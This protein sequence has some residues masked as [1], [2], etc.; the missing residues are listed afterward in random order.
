MNH[1]G[2][3]TKYL[4][5]IDGML[6]MCPHSH[7]NNYYSF[8]SIPIFP[9]SFVNADN[10][11]N[12]KGNQHRTLGIAKPLHICFPSLVKNMQIFETDMDCIHIKFLI[13]QLN[14]QSCSQSHRQNKS[15]R[16]L[17]LKIQL[18]YC[19]HCL[20]QI[21]M[22]KNHYHSIKNSPSFPSSFS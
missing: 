5:T 3:N 14:E 10:I 22:T 20:H 16:K 19:K 11:Q 1:Q 4:R 17:I 9:K 15:K 8:E 21:N 7:P 12:R 6:C 2:I 13:Q 18:K